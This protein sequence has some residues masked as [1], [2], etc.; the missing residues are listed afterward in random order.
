[1]TLLDWLTLLSLVGLVVSAF[2]ATWAAYTDRERLLDCSVVLMFFFGFAWAACN[3]L[4][5]VLYTH[6]H[7][8]GDLQ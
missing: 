1:M 5:C 7:V 6:T 4:F 3:L 2:L 8:R